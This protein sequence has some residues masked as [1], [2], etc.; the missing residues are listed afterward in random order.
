[1]SRNHKNNLRQ[2]IKDE[3]VHRF[4]SAVQEEI[5]QYQ[6]ATRLYDKK[7][8]ELEE[9]INAVQRDTDYRKSQNEQYYLKTQDS[10]EKSIREVDKT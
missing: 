5:R 10:F 9:K 3:Y 1:M 2:L 8:S 6:L 7:L 4:E